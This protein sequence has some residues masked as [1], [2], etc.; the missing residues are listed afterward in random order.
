MF[1][2][3][4]FAACLL[5]ALFVGALL[6]AGCG[7][8]LTLKAGWRVAA[9]ASHSWRGL[10][11]RRAHVVRIAAL[12]SVLLLVVVLKAAQAK[13]LWASQSAQDDGYTI[14]VSVS[15][16]VLHVTVRNSKG[17]PVSGLAKG[18]FQV[19]EDGV[20]QEIKFFSHDDIPVEAGL[21]IDNSGSMRPKR[22]EVITAALAFARASNPQD[23]M[24]VVNFNET[25]SFG[26]PENVPFT[27]KVVQLESA[28]ARVS[29]KGET[30]LYDAVA[31]GLEHLKKGN[32]DK[33]VLIVISD[34]AD[35]ASKHS[36]A[37][38]VAMAEKSDA[39]IYS[40]GLFDEGDPD[41]RFDVLKQLA[42]AAGGEAFLPESAKDVTPIC[43]RIAHDLRSQ[44]TLAYVPTN[45]NQDGTYR[46]VQV[47][48]DAPG[49]GRV[50]VRTRAGYK[51]PTKA[52]TA[53]ENQDQS[54]ATSRK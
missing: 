8:F 2:L 26:L 37:Q 28:L 31:A 39:I 1:I 44:Y 32:R 16:V 52:Q 4:E 15:Q 17:T 25:V 21:I 29:A 7:I 53:G 48:A 14:K 38:I 30:A 43:Q 47:K 49:R 27:D 40:V 13:G 10:Q 19:Y 3:R 51:A 35:N 11:S 6:C 23:Q 24:F 45:R 41:Q 33:K 20:L 9:R 36:K 22:A 34:G 12:V 18:N 46:A 5:V 50:S 54:S 42:K